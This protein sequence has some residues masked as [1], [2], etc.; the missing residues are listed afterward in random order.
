MPAGVTI[1]LSP[2]GGRMAVLTDHVQEIT[3]EDGTIWEYDEVKFKLPEDRE[4]TAKSIKENFDAWWEYG[5]QKEEE[6]TIESRV[7]AL[8]DAIMEILGV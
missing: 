2:D 8:E 5:Q 4:E 6:V 7:S 1:E 3:G